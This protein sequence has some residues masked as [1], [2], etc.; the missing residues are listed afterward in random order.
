MQ[1]KIHWP[2]I[3]LYSFLTVVSIQLFYYLFFFRR[4]SFYKPRLKDKSQQ[5][6]VS[7]IVCARDEAAKLARNL[8]GILVQSY[9]TSHEVVVVNHNS[10][11]ETRYLRSEER[12]V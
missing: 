8:P 5:H 7:V 11:D 10:Q 6:P 3:I 1:V 12:R 2:D 9:P 4:L